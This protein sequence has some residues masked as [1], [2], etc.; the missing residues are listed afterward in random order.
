MPNKK[1]DAVVLTVAHAAFRE[2]DLDNLKKNH[3]IV[4]D[5]KNFFPTEKINKSL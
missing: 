5:V 3:S 1:C 4:Y 2:I